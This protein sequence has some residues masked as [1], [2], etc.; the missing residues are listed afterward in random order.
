MQIDYPRIL[1]ALISQGHDYADVFNERTETTTI[2]KENGKFDKLASR[3]DNGYGLRVIRNWKSAYAFSNLLNQKSLINLAAETAIM[4][5][6]ENANT[7]HK[8]LTAKNT[9]SIH[10]IDKMPRDISL[11]EKIR[12]VNS[13]E[14]VSKKFHKTVTQVNVTYRDTVRET[15]IANSDGTIVSQKLTYTTLVVFVVA[16]NGDTIQTGFHAEGGMMG[17]ELFRVFPPEEI[18]L[19]AAE[20]AVAM[21][22]ARPAPSGMMQVVL[23]S[24]AGGTMIHE[25]VGHGLEADHI[26]DGTSIY[27]DKIGKMVA[28]EL[29]T[30]IDDPTIQNKRGSFDFDDEGVPAR[31][32]VLIE[33]GILKNYMYDVL[34]AMKTGTISNGSGRRESYRY[35]PVPRMSNTL[36][37]P[38]DSDPGTIIRSVEHGL[39][40]KKMG[41]GEVNTL[42]GDFVFQV[43]EGYII[44]KG[45]LGEM[46]RGATIAGNGP[47]ILKTID[48][49]GRDLGYGIG[50]CG[51]DGQGVPVSDAQPTLRIPE[52]IVGGYA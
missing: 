49:V 50:T 13:A 36:I 34:T 24:E 11:E 7:E 51:K 27:K 8:K 1:K 41:G 26:H 32:K 6:S 45:A 37:A 23:S 40:V 17:L 16:S 3:M 44:E 14:N 15:E 21:L 31:K 20:Q 35:R 19:K 28:S 2:L 39:F 10:K 47:E 25:A 12:I 30:V 46:V 22:S 38:G 5:N 4:L 18:A 29:I 42:T 43:I 9:N 33:K 48:M 52:I